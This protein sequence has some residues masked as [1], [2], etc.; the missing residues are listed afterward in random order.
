MLGTFKMWTIRFTEQF[1]SIRMSNDVCNEIDVSK[2]NDKYEL[3]EN[4]LY[5]HEWFNA[6]LF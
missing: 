6:L 4:I 2:S 3:K 1:P 5:V